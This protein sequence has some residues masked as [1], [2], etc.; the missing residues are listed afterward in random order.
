MTTTRTR[1][2][3]KA[4]LKGEKR[5]GCGADVF[6]SAKKAREN[7]ESY[8]VLLFWDQAA[9]LQGGKK[10]KGEKAVVIKTHDRRIKG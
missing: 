9:S 4:V 10:E 6:Q 8:K 3:S 1:V 2:T 7:L 5:N